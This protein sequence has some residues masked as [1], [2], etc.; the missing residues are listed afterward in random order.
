MDHIGEF[1]R[2]AVDASGECPENFKC[3]ICLQLVSEPQECAS[4][5]Q[6]FCKSCINGWLTKGKRTCP[7]CVKEV[8]PQP[9]NRILRKFLDSAKLKG[10][11]ASNGHNTCEKGETE[12][13]YEQLFQHLANECPFV[14]VSCPMNC[15]ISFAR[16]SWE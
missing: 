12:M 10:C 15:G 9:L 1:L 16:K 3:F 4:C 14:K 6:L 5:N 8:T 7:H 2:S 11:P 13:T